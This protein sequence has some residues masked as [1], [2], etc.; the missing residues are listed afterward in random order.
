MA[1]QE[2]RRRHV[3]TYLFL[4][5]GLLLTL[6]GAS[7]L[8]AQPVAT[9]YAKKYVREHYPWIQPLTVEV[10]WPFETVRMTD[11]SFDKGWVK[12]HLTEVRVNRKTRAVTVSGGEVTADLDKRP[13]GTASGERPNVTV[14]GLRLVTV[15]KGKVTAKASLVGW[16][17][18]L[19]TFTAA[20][21]ETPW[22]H[23]ET[24]AGSYEPKVKLIL[25]KA[26]TKLPLP[27]KI[28][29]LGLEE[30]MLTG[31]DITVDETSLAL[32]SKKLFVHAMTPAKEILTAGD[33][34]LAQG[35]FMGTANKITLGWVQ[36]QHP[37]LSQK[38]ERF[39]GL[40]GIY[41]PATPEL[42]FTTPLNI[43]LRPTEQ[44]VQVLGTCQE[45]SSV[46]ARETILKS[47][48]FTGRLHV[49]VKM[50]PSPTITM[51]PAACVPTSCSTFQGLKQAFKYTAIRA[52]G[53]PFERTS[54][55]GTPDWIPLGLAGRM[56]LAVENLE[57]PG[58]R[59]HQGFIREAYENSLVENVK[60]GKFVR[61]GSTITMQ[62]AKNLYL[63]REKTLIRKAQELLLAM[64][65]EK[66]LTKGEILELYLNVV[67]FG[68]NVYGIKQGSKHWFKKLP[69]ALEMVEAYWLASILP[70]PRKV[71][72][73]TEKS[74]EGTMKLME[75]LAKQG[76]ITGFVGGLDDVDTTG[77]ESSP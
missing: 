17:G 47:L 71:G 21:V 12:G 11:V 15:T 38:P 53:S 32:T 39:E 29:G 43:Q 62:L 8:A 10:A 52:D 5:G 9:W 75:A 58:F 23:V 7:L 41:F 18:K 46:V 40:S 3:P 51:D 33:I 50:K 14:T 55:P 67:E 61:G 19:V 59:Y 73:P 26:V 68:P 76:K 49:T 37:W 69:E 4:I 72:P 30:V 6:F 35:S 57:D 44:S 16:D 25:S 63:Q 60:T 48:T 22:A 45:W 34:S 56:P 42:V 77:W 64:A 13:T 28:P 74:L 24:G 2:P 70:R 27:V 54:G 1:D 31:E 66:C 65:L 20:F 36:F